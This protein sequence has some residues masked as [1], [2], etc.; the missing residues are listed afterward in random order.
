[1]DNVI[2]AIIEKILKN[3]RQKTAATIMILMY[4]IKFLPFEADSDFIPI[5]D[6]ISEADSLVNDLKKYDIFIKETMMPII[7]L[8]QPECKNLNIP[9]MRDLIVGVI[10]G[11]KSYFI[12]I[13]D[14]N[15][16]E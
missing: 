12:S 2:N 14:E 5:L 7:K 3:D 4:K 15:D 10:Y 13:K 11:L 8:I 16:D 1:M 6:T 9:Q